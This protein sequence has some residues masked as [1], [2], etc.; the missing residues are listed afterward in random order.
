MQKQSRLSTE[1]TDPKVSKWLTRYQNSND[2]SYA[3]GYDE[4]G[5]EPEAPVHPK[6]SPIEKDN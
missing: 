5:A 4:E 2:N 6:E 1:H 3:I